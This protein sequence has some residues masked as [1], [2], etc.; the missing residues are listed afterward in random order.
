MSK[1]A[2]IALALLTYYLAGMYLSLPLMIMGIAELLMLPFLFALPRYLRKNISAHFVKQSETILEKANVSC[3]IVIRNTGRLTA[4]RCQLRFRFR[5]HT[6][7]KSRSVKLYSGGAKGDSEAKLTVCADWCGLALVKLDR[8][9]VYDYLG[10]FSAGKAVD[11]ETD[12]AVFPREQ[13]LQ[14]I[15]PDSAYGAEGLSEYTVNR[16]GEANDEIRQIREYRT[17]DSHRRIHWN[18]SAKTDK[19]WIKEY[20]R[21]TDTRAEVLVTAADGMTAEKLSLLYKLLSA[22]VLGLL[23]NVAA[24][25]VSWYDSEK[26]TFV[27]AEVSDIDGCREMLLMLYRTDLTGFAEE[28]P[29]HFLRVTTALELYRENTLLYR[30]SESEL[31]RELQEKIITL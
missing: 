29:E 12:I 10:L 9:R 3:G 14:I 17:G 16:P 30:F 26:K 8:V 11:E 2:F 1:F 21:E 19:L 23:A 20:E 4:N 27:S 18:Q 7:E 28:L 31:D 13:A 22:L 5:Y 25:N 6:E 24:V 15:M